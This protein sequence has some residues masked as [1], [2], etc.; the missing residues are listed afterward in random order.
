MNEQETPK[1]KRIAR[2]TVDSGANMGR[3]LYGVTFYSSEHEYADD[4]VLR[5]RVETVKAYFDVD[6]ADSVSIYD[7]A[8]NLVSF[9]NKKVFERSIRESELEALFKEFEESL[10]D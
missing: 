9:L 5:P 6:L 4:V 1:G 10:S 3:P 8:R 7:K 2:F